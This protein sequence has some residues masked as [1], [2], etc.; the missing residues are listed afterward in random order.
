MRWSGINHLDAEPRT[1]E[2]TA[3][4]KSIYGGDWSWNRRPILILYNGH[5]YAASMNGMP[6]GT[7]TISN[8]FEGHFCIH[9]KNS[10][11]HG[12]KKIDSDHQSAVTAASRA[13]W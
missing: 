9:F 13:A 2:D 6:H 8:G 5:V 4:L 7:T 10:M 1:S 12:T 11:T 3:T